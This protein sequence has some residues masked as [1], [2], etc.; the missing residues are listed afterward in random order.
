[1][2]ANVEKLSRRKK[3]YRRPQK[4]KLSSDFHF[5]A[6]LDQVSQ[7]H[8]GKQIDPEKTSSVT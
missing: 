8:A 4:C 2:E 3:L 6:S 5:T 1:M 7:T